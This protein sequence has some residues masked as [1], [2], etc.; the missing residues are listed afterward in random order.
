MHY[1]QALPEYL[2]VNLYENLLCHYFPQISIKALITLCAYA[3]RGYAFGHFG[4][5]TYVYVYIYLST[6]KKQAV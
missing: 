2:M 6:K 5:C 3:Q 4:L 1:H